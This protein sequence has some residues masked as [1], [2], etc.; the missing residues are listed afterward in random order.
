MFRLFSEGG[1]IL[2]TSEISSRTIGANHSV[3]WRNFRLPDR[4]LTRNDC[5]IRVTALM[6]RDGRQHPMQTCGA[7]RNRAAIF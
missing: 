5:I 6:L 3:D 4:L 7:L 2:R 1:T